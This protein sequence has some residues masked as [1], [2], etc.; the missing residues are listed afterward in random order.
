MAPQSEDTCVETATVS[1]P[2]SGEWT[3]GCES[4]E[5]GRGYARYYSP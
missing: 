1:E 5:P 2:V 4:S 3:A